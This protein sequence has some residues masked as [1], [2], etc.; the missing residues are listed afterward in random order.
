MPAQRSSLRERLLRYE[1]PHRPTVNTTMGILWES[2]KRQCLPTAVAAIKV[3]SVGHLTREDS[4]ITTT[5]QPTVHDCCI[6]GAL[7]A[8]SS[9]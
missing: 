7:Q 8:M 5:Q 3:A 6:V 4:T 2:N 9:D 1:P